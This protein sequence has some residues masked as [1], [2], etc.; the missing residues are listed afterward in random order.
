LATREL[1]CTPEYWVRHVRESVRFAD[2]VRALAEEG[3]SAFLEL[4]PDGVLSAL[5]HQSLD[6]E[7][8]VA[9]LL[10]KDREEESA[11]LTALARVHVEGVRIE[12]AGLFDGTGAQR[13]DLPTY[14]FQHE[15]YWPVPTAHRGDVSGAGLTPAEHPL[16]GAVVP[17][18]D[19]ESALLTGRLSLKAQPWL[20]D[21]TAG[22]VVVFPASGFLELVIS[23]ADQVGCDRV[24]ELT[25]AEPLVLP[26]DGAVAVQVWVGAPDDSG[27]RTVGCYARSAESAPDEPWVCHATGMLV[28]GARPAD[29]DAQVWPP[30]DAVAMDVEGFYEASGFGPAF[31]AVRSVWRRGEEVFVEAA[32]PGQLGDAGEF[33]FHPALLEAAVQA[34]GFAGVD[35]DERLVALSWGG[36]SLHAAGAAVVRARILRLG[37]DAVSVE[38]ADVG[39]APVLSVE[40]LT[41]GAVSGS[42]G[43][44]AGGGRDG[45]LR[46][47]WVVAPV[48]R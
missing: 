24:E 40:S 11:L 32:V 27:A 41:L 2:G 18:A 42:L 17:L 39:G 12:W 22:G 29:F 48:G 35:D 20:A 25:L 21:Y 14:A 3:V 46:L 8:V 23:A 10:R 26:E 19:S 30:R 6:Q 5:A 34:A 7:C 28:T 13:V 38:V 36:V 15:R 33:G 31:Q 43:A 16:L 1:V 37:E 9:P 44:S 45:L 47:E 4:G